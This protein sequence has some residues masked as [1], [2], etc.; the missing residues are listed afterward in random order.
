[1]VGSYICA[2]ELATHAPFHNAAFAAYEREI[3]D[4]VKCSRTFAVSAAKKVVPASPLDPWILVQAARLTNVLPGWVNR[5]I[6][7]LNSG[8]SVYMTPSP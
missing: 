1:M 6:A 8:V 7:K 3:G 5:A 4:Y 2:G